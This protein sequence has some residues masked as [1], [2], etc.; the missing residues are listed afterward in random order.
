MAERSP[1][2]VIG[3]LAIL[4]AGGVYVPIDPDYPKERIHYMLEDSNVS[5]LLLQHHLLEGTDY[6]SHTVFLDDPSSYDAEPSNLNLS[7]MP[8]QLAY[9]IY[10]SGTTGNPKGTLI[11]HKNVVRLL[12]NNKNVFD[13]NASDTWTLFHSFCFDFSVWEMYGALLYGGKLVIVP[14]QIA[15]NPERYL[16]LLKSEA[17]TILN[18]TPSYFYQLMQEERA[19][20]ESNLNIRKIIFGGEALNPSFLKDWKLKYPLTQL[21]NMYGITETTVHV[22]YKEITERE[23][24]EGRSNIGQPIPTLQAYILDEYQRIQVMGI[25]GELYVAGEGL[26]RGYLNRPELTAEKFVEHPFAAGEKCTK[27]EMSPGGCLTAISSI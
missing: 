8:N 9:V 24:N 1:E 23:I 6:Q 3:I 11:E 12:F 18:Q 15:K 7:V 2:M 22:T 16:Q 4:K 25:P 17:V 13:F 19:D 10:T 27:R 5:I 21:I 14:K 26:A 20:P